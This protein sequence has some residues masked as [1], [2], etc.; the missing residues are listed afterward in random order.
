MI[1]T[2]KVVNTTWTQIDG[3]RFSNPTNN[4]YEYAVGSTPPDETMSGHPLLPYK[5]V[6]REEFDANDLFYFRGATKGVV[7]V[8][9]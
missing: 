9:K 7:A 3:D 8:T 1:T 4:I 6:T 2:N 5:G